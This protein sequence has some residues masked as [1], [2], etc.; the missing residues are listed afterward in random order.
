MPARVAWHNNIYRL[1]MSVYAE[2]VARMSVRIAFSVFMNVFIQHFPNPRLITLEI[3]VS[4]V[5]RAGISE[6]VLFRVRT[7]WKVSNW[8]LFCVT[9]NCC[10]SDFSRHACWFASQHSMMDIHFNEHFQI[11]GHELSL[12]TVVSGFKVG[13]LARKHWKRENYAFVH[14]SSPVLLFFVLQR[15]ETAVSVHNACRHIPLSLWVCA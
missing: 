11:C 9:R 12:L 3:A 7:C 1:R 8:H 4:S 13:G 14:I 6:T 2:I 5:S 15:S 10:K